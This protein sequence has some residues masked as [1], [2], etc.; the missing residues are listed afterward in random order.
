M[1]LRNQQHTVAGKIRDVINEQTIING[2][3]EQVTKELLELRKGDSELRK[4]ELELKKQELELRERELKLRQKKLE[5]QKALQSPIFTSSTYISAQELIESPASNSKKNSS[6]QTNSTALPN[7]ILQEEKITVDIELKNRPLIS[8]SKKKDF[9][10]G[11]INWD[12]SENDDKKIEELQQKLETKTIHT[13]SLK[14]GG[15]FSEEKCLSILARA[16]KNPIFIH[17]SLI[18]MA[19]GPKRIKSL[20][21][22]FSTCRLQL[23]NLTGNQ[24]GVGEDGPKTIANKILTIPSLTELNLSK[25]EINDKGVAVL[26]NKFKEKRF[27]TYTGLTSLNLADNDIGKSGAI[28]LAEILSN[29]KLTFLS[30]K[31]NDIKDIGA[32]AFITQ[33]EK[34]K[35][36]LIKLNKLDVSDQKEMISSKIQPLKQALQEHNKRFSK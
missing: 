5:R 34:D 1:M 18:S 14:Y 10:G 17:L 28:G 25:N 16:L 27:K 21:E 9:E 8:D 7:S 13:I 26:I 19:I 36:G 2:L 24:L 22:G 33:I 20:A 15:K 29:T 23:L 4:Q 35:K 12:Y 3:S 31:G 6:L 11:M 30:L 32:Q